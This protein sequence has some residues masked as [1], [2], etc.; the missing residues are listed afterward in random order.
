MAW[1]RVLQV[2]GVDMLV[3]CGF[4]ADHTAESQN[5]VESTFL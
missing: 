4:A 1:S 5:R 3:V 2:S